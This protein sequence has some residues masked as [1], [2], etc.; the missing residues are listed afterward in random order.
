MSS[1]RASLFAT[2]ALAAALTVGALAAPAGAALRHVD[3]TV[4]S[5]N[6]DNRTFKLSTQSGTLRVKVNGTTEF[7]RLGGFG[8]L[9][10]GLQIEVDYVRTSNGIVAKQIEP[11]GGNGGSGGGG[12]GGSDDPPGDDHGGHG[13]GSDDGPNHT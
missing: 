9:R 10:K 4:V 11:Q 5:K 2:A 1:R 13:G 7:E 8:A 12:G 6:A 3:G